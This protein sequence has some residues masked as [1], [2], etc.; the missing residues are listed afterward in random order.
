MRDVDL[1]YQNV[2]GLRTKADCFFANVTVSNYSIFCLTETWLCPN[3]GSSDYF[4]P[5]FVVH[6][7]DHD[8]FQGAGAGGG[9]LVAVDRRYSSRRRQDLENIPE[10]LFVQ[11][12]YA[13]Q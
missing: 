4:P 11:N 13:K 5:G 6:R 7:R 1:L 9:V 2:R 8:L 10:S 12:E 3:I